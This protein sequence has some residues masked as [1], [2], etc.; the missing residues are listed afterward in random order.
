V[1]Q[2]DTDS[3]VKLT[4][5][6]DVVLGS[7]VLGSI[8][9]D[10]VLGSIINVE[11]GRIIRL[12]VRASAPGGRGGRREEEVQDWDVEGVRAACTEPKLQRA[13]PSSRSRRPT[14]RRG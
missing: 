14:C 4:A 12:K 11:L 7:I 6:T 8:I 1:C 5:L 2:V 13:E 3:T 9:N 10:V